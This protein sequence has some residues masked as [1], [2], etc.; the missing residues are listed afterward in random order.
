LSGLIV[1]LAGTIASAQE[2]GS[3]GSSGRGGRGGFGGATASYG[4]LLRMP[5]VQ[6][7]LGFSESQTSQIEE[8]EKE[9]MDQIRSSFA[10]INFQEIQSLSQEEREKRFADMRKKGEEI[11]K[12]VEEKVKK[13]LDAKQVTRLDQLVLQ[14]AGASAFS[15]PEVIKKLDLTEDQQ[16]K[17]KKIQDDSRTQGRGRF[18]RNMSEEQRTEAFKKMQESRE[19]AQKDALG[20]L[21]DEQMMTW[22]E[23]CGKEFKFPA[24]R[25]M[26]GM[27]RAGATGQQP[28]P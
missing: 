1:V 9:V 5:E 16:A 26:G 18:G 4:M 2:S 27:F 3:G 10:N 12:Q 21:T 17:I 7:E 23:M 20:V 19:K 24:T 25:P 11:G 8:T 6:K 15:R 22:G 28:N 13:I 14:Y